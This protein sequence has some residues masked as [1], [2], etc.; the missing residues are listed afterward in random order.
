MKIKKITWQRRYDFNAILECEHCS[1]EQE[2]KTG[3]NDAYYHAKVLPSITCS[4][5]KKNREGD[6]GDNDHGS[7]PV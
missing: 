3:Y 1:N 2:L 5:C 4:K 6:V 7:N